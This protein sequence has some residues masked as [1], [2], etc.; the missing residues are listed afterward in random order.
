MKNEN[1]KVIKELIEKILQKL[2][3][4]FEDI[5]ICDDGNDNF[6][7]AIKSKDSGILIGAEGNNIKALNHIIKQIVRKNENEKI[8]NINFFVDVNDYQTK[9]IERIKNKALEMAKKAVFFRRDIELDPMTSFERLIVH[10]VLADNENIET[11]SFGI[12]SSRK[13]CIK[14][15]EKEPLN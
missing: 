7:F 1:N 10:S 2:S 6:R 12:G 5:T 15:K 9:N 11:A 13:I 8:G 4:D 3:I 14:F